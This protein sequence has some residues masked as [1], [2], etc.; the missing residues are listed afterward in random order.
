MILLFT[1]LE[2]CK[3]ASIYR[4]QRHK[5]IQLLLLFTRLNKSESVIACVLA[6]RRAWDFSCVRDLETCNRWART[7]SWASLGPKA[8]AYRRP[9]LK[10]SCVF[11][12]FFQKNT[13]EKTGHKC[14][15]DQIFH[16][17]KRV[18]KELAVKQ[19]VKGFLSQNSFKLFP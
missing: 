16:I 14:A 3:E 5:K 8:C 10:C 11:G 4:Q 19:M 17:L 6:C 15:I 1:I 12:I 13:H 9:V 2:S 7:R 18:K